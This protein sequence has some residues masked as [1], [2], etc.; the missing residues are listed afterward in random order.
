M[1][2]LGSN[3]R[4]KIVISLLEFD[5]SLLKFL[6]HLLTTVHAQRKHA[7]KGNLQ[8]KSKVREGSV[9]NCPWPKVRLKIR[10]CKLFAKARLLQNS[11]RL[12]VCR[13]RL[14]FGGFLQCLKARESC[15]SL[16]LHPWK[17]KALPQPPSLSPPSSPQQG[18]PRKI[19]SPKSLSLGKI[20]AH[21]A[22]LNG[23]AWASSKEFKMSYFFYCQASDPTQVTSKI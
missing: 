7:C 23:D 11:A 18:F 21:G 20:P 4:L 13:Y 6:L 1:G 19:S 17:H 10:L 8:K 12:C 3:L 15:S 14:L 5:A 16:K 22:A 2:D 9:G